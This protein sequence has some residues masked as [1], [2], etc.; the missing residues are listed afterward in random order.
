M[1]LLL[2]FLKKLNGSG[3]NQIQSI[4]LLHTCISGSKYYYNDIDVILDEVFQLFD[5]Y[6]ANVVETA[7]SVLISR[8]HRREDR[9]T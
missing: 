8:E 4:H 5:Y 3:I 9:M 6:D 1:T 7:G 2:Y